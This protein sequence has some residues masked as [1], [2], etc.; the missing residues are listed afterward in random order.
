MSA[1]RFRSAFPSRLPKSGQGYPLS[2]QEFR[3]RALPFLTADMP[4]SP[5]SFERSKAS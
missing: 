1:A 4:L 3:L 2:R 5:L